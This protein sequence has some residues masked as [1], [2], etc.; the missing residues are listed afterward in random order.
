M[1]VVRFFKQTRFCLAN[2]GQKRSADGHDHDASADRFWAMLARLKRVCL[3]K[4]TQFFQI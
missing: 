3:K 2:I 4:R 1:N